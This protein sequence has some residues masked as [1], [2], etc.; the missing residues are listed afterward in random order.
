MGMQIKKYKRKCIRY[1]SPSMIVTL[2]MIMMIN[3][4]CTPELS[5]LTEPTT[6]IRLFCIILPCLFI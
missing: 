2:L 4:Y 3:A 5:L 6:D 1:R